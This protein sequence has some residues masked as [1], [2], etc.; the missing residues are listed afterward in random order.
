MLD[1]TIQPIQ[2]WPGEKRLPEDRRE[3]QFKAGWSDTLELLERELAMIRATDVVIQA[4]CPREALRNDGRF[5]AG[6]RLYGPAV[7][8][9]FETKKIGPL[10]YPCDTFNHWTDNVRAIALALEALRKVDRYGVG[11]GGEQYRG[12]L[13]LEDKSHKGPFSTAGDAIQWVCKELKVPTLLVPLGDETKKNIRRYAMA[14]FHPDRNDGLSE[15]WS[16]WQ[17]A[18]VVLGIEV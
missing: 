12:W 6:A 2:K 5:R 13:A 16:L 4:D 11:R 10:S 15:R 9:S 7:I 17:H 3:S 1:Y 18:A 8:L 14:A